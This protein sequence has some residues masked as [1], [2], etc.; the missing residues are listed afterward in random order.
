M[1]EPIPAFDLK[2]HLV[3]GTLEL[4]I[5]TPD[6]F[7]KLQECAE[8]L[9]TW[10]D[11]PNPIVRKTGDLSGWFPSGVEG[12][13]ALAIRLR[14]TG[15][16]IGTSRYYAFSDRPPL[17]GI[18]FTFIAATHRNS[19]QTNQ[20]LKRLML[21]HAFESYDAVWFHVLP[22]NERSKAAVRKLG[23]IPHGEQRLNLTDTAHT[24]AV[25]ELK[26]QTWRGRSKTK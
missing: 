4:Q 11:Y 24:Y 20:E 15:Q 6:L 5:L 1:T 7:T 18:G 14:A 3:G 9:D 22:S 16:I 12:S 19:G 25:F 2:P 13:N 17:I 21:G 23:A 8:D 10:A 26:K